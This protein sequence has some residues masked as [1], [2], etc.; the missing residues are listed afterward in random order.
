MITLEKGDVV[1][2]EN[3]NKEKPL[4]RKTKQT[5][6]WTEY[7]IQ[8]L[9]DVYSRDDVS[10]Q[11]LRKLINKS[12]SSICVMAKKLNLNNKPKVKIVT[13]PEEEIEFLKQ[14]Y[15]QHDTTLKE[16]ALTLKK[17]EFSVKLKANELGLKKVTELEYLAKTRRKRCYMC[18]EI[19]S[20]DEFQKNRSKS[21]GLSTYCVYCSA[22]RK[23]IRAQ[24]NNNKLN[25]NNVSVSKQ[26]K[27]ECTSCHEVKLVTE[28]YDFHTKCKECRKK[29][30]K[31]RKLKDLI[32]KGYC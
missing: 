7:Q 18:K 3:D 15:S 11:E 14:A 12:E 5:R 16:I 29:Q 20:Y 21:D 17:K 26:E 4:V 1:M 9:I 23:K 28:F 19:Y 27:R 25:G 31:E 24:E 2:S 13:W 22:L 8:T 32:E 10:I 30:M 6:G